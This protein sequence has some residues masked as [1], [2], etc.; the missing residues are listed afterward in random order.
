VGITVEGDRLVV[1]ISDDGVG[2]G[3]APS[4]I[5]GGN[6]IPGMRE[7]AS[8]L[9]GHLEAAPRPGDGFVVRAMLPLDRPA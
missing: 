4:V 5:G 1:E 7:R 9:G 6:G 8:A 3:A 2:A